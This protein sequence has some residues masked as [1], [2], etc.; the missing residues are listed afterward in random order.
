MS[1]TKSTQGSSP[2]TD[3]Y[4]ITPRSDTSTEVGTQGT[5]KRVM[6]ISTPGSSH[7]ISPRTSSSDA[8]EGSGSQGQRS[9]ELKEA[10]IT[11][12]ST[13]HSSTSMASSTK[14]I[15]L[16]EVEETTLGATSSSLIEEDVEEG[17]TLLNDDKFLADYL[18][19]VLDGFEIFDPQERDEIRK[20]L[21][22]EQ[23]SNEAYEVAH[24]A[25]SSL[26][27]LHHVVKEKDELIMALQDAVAS[28]YRDAMAQQERDQKGLEQLHQTFLIREGQTCLDVTNSLQQLERGDGLAAQTAKLFDQYLHEL[29][30]QHDD[31]NKELER[32]LASWRS[33]CEE[34]ETGLEHEKQHWQSHLSTKL[35]D[36][37]LDWEQVKDELQI[38]QGMVTKLKE[39][40]EE[41]DE[42]LGIYR[43]SVETLESLL[44]EE[45]DRQTELAQG[46]QQM[47]VD[48]RQTLSKVSAVNKQLRM[49]KS[50]TSKYQMQG[51]TSDLE[52]KQLQRKVDQ[53][54]GT[55][56]KM[57]VELAAHRRSSKRSKESECKGCE[58]LVETQKQ[59][60]LLRGCISPLVAQILELKER[61]NITGS[62]GN[63]SCNVAP[64]NLE[65]TTGLEDCIQEL[66]PESN[67]D[68][69]TDQNKGMSKKDAQLTSHQLCSIDSPRTFVES[70]MR[71]V[72]N[73]TMKKLE[74]HA[75]ISRR[76]EFLQRKLDTC[77]Q[78]MEKGEREISRFGATVEHLKCELRKSQVTNRELEAKLK[79]RVEKRK[80]N[81]TDCMR[82][83]GLLGNIEMLEMESTLLKHEV[84]VQKEGRIGRLEKELQ[85]V[86]ASQVRPQ[87]E[88]SDDTKTSEA[89]STWEKKISDLESTIA[90]K[91][92]L[93]LELRFEVD[94]VTWKLDQVGKRFDILFGALDCKK[95]EFDSP[96][97][98]SILENIFS[99]EK[100]NSPA[101]KLLKEKV[102][103]RRGYYRSGSREKELEGLVEDLVKVVEKVGCDNEKLRSTCEDT[104]KHME[105][106]KELRKMVE[107]LQ[108]QVAQVG[109]SPSRDRPNS[110]QVAVIT[111]LKSQLSNLADANAG[112]LRALRDTEDQCSGLKQMVQEHFI[113]DNPTMPK[114]DKERFRNNRRICFSEDEHRKQDQRLQ[115]QADKIIKLENKLATDSQVIRDLKE[116]LER[117]ENE[118]DLTYGKLSIQILRDNS[119]NMD[120]GKTDMWSFPEPD[121]RHGDDPKE[122]PEEIFDNENLLEHE[123]KLTEAENQRLR[124]CI[125]ALKNPA[126]LEEIRDLK[127]EYR[128][129]TKV[130]DRY[131]EL[132]RIYSRQIGVPF[133][134]LR[135][136]GSD[137]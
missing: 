87:Q 54:N 20:S 65:D 49:L 133:N 127:S 116:Q 42:Q 1:T 6:M 44:D 86:R 50:D 131:E 112:L 122:G 100:L 19:T 82:I 110:A 88:N 18:D 132:L 85:K 23:E 80:Q 67:S 70:T 38:S 69:Q 79:R 10:T 137:L 83:K 21:K 61:L 84:M 93:I 130:C 126:L 63:Q 114:Q 76:T 99:S 4:E 75:N 134:S 72:E 115:A 62:D 129:M 125:K 68:T 22:A 14:A 58:T 43:E 121:T 103:T 120:Q 40:L 105:K 66:V 25:Q 41:K 2:R 59:V 3:V 109:L 94:Q 39:M 124:K 53:L 98:D 55:N 13:K 111:D 26:K 15:S 107:D 8:Q 12:E 118:L 34:L 74:G 95:V 52:V 11:T 36:T 28:A 77:K 97:A 117:K 104:V 47:T 48:T 91:D 108:S 16:G 128:R 60:Q 119:E 92:S 27:R 89:S 123:R 31:H 24:V 57:A 73:E 81:P 113:E 51:N 32:N 101:L 56:H 90:S 136:R 45:K 35:T 106:N 33:R 64:K 135:K 17:S 96:I 102:L 7:G 5:S 78:A 30:A 46:Y 9:E 71:L 37:V 29:S